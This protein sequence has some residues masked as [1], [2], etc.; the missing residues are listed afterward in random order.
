MKQNHINTASDYT[1]S[2]PVKTSTKWFFAM[3]DIFQGGFFNIVNFFYGIF[4]T[5]VMGI[6][7]FWAGVVFLIGRVFDA[8]TDPAMG[9]ISDNTRTRFG[10]RRPYF[11]IGT[12]FILIM[13]IAMWYPVN[14][15][16]DSVRV[17]YFIVA[18]MLMNTAST[19]ISIP[20]L[21]MTAELS[22]DYNER[23]SITN[24][25]IIVSIT[26]SLICA[27]VP[28]LLVSAVQDIH[29]GYILMSVVFGLFFALPMLLVFF[30]VPERK[31]FSQG[32]KS[33]WK[34]MF[35][36]LRIKVFR[37]F[38]LMYLCIVVAMDTTA[39]IFAYYM[40]YNLGRSDEL[41]F[42]LGTLLISQ[43]ALVPLAS[44]FIAATSKNVGIV[45]GNVGWIICAALSFFIGPDSPGFL[46]YL[47]AGALGG[48]M[49]FSV[50]GFTSIFGD[51]TEVGEYHF[52]H[53][54]EGSFSG[55]Q[56]FVR[57]C[58]AAIAN[59]AALTLLGIV[60][61]INPVEIVENG[62]TIIQVQEQTSV[63]LYTIR[64]ILGMTSILLLI[65][66]T[67]IAI[68][69]KLTKSK[70]AALGNYLDRKRAGLE[71]DE[72]EEQSVAEICKPLI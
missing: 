42:V 33:S 37:R 61:F 3:G 20:F 36:T 17:I 57:K 40:T 68:R 19:I 31:Q 59:W 48:F 8:V 28:M 67:I 16:S 38:I 65:P 44:K 9:V 15:D 23:T 27:V 2:D 51:M 6:S 14:V 63:V 4:L 24:I 45:V 10:R 46:I 1:T 26:S 54:V 43:V 72:K 60:G 49:G 64:G 53:R 13:F 69:W 11:L 41:S 22:T 21:A 56:Q 66:S 70:H 34:E 5:D 71:I 50:I 30:K 55:I 52:G 12:P 18:Y 25:R 29:T 47:L 35:A 58:A 7:P 32:E 62:V 39:M